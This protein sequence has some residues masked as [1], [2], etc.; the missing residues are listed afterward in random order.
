MNRADSTAWRSF[1]VFLALTSSLA[2]LAGRARA[3]VYRGIEFPQ[4]AASFASRVVAYNPALVNDEPSESHRQAANAL[5]PPDDTSDTRAVSLGSGGGITL[6]FLDNALTGSGNATPDLWIFEVGGDVEAT[7]VEISKDGLRWFAVGKS[8]GGTG[9]IDIDAF[10]FRPQ[11]RFYYVR[12]RDDPSQGDTTGP[13]VG[14]DIDAVGVISSP[15]SALAILRQ[16]ASQVVVAGDPV[17][18]SVLA[19][20]PSPL[21][22]QWRQNGDEIP[23]ATLSALTIASASTTN[24]GAYTVTITSGAETLTSTEALLTVLL[25]PEIVEPPKT[26]F[27]KPGAN[28]GFQVVA[29]GSPPL[30]YQWTFNGHA[31]T[32]ATLASLSLTN[33]QL[34][35]VGIY[36]VEVSNAAG[37]VASPPAWLTFDAPATLRGQVTDALRGMPLEDVWVTASGVSGLSDTQGQYVLTN[38]PPGFLKANF[39]AKIRSGLAPLTVEFINLSLDAAATVQAAKLGYVSYTNTQVSIRPAADVRLDFSLSPTNVPGLRLVLNWGAK[40]R[41]LDAHLLTPTIESNA[42]EVAFP[43]RNRGHLESA[44]Y[45]QLDVDRTTGFGP[46]TITISRLYPGT[47]Y[48]YVHNYEDD[49]GFTGDLSGSSAIVQI[50]SDQ[51]VLRT[52]SVPESG[53]GVYWL[54]CS[55]DGAT[56]DITLFNRITDQKPSPADLASHA[57]SAPLA[58]ASAAAKKSTN[59]TY[60]WDFGDG[61]TSVDAAP[62]HPYRAGGAYTVSLRMTTPDNRVDRITKTGFITVTIPADSDRPVLKASLSGE[63]ITL[64]WVAATAGYQLESTSDLVAAAWTAVTVAPT[65]LNELTYAVTLPLKGPQFFRLRK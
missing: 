23:G 53:S 40:P 9:G 62:T 35:D 45:A 48:Y 43:P 57:A 41:D 21:R 60:E 61:A 8:P 34:E 30:S 58:A 32:N 56:G 18:L 51:G 1:L 20:G 59:P 17:T 46:E 54:V 31:L 52:A 24:A 28:V 4:G 14:A 49:Q 7:F 3:E 65:M 36:A 63:K 37:R 42:Y 27:A 6:Q 50:L 55:I 22:Y 39:D 38:V 12:L 64:S 13:S 10:G 33:V 16:P 11:D 19:D 15:G 5:G 26:V 47:Y 25:P 2:A 44:P 29:K